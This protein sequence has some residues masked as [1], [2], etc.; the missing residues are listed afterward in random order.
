MRIERTTDRELIRSVVTHPA[1][2]P[3]VSDDGSPDAG[4]YEPVIGD[5]IL[6]LAAWAGD[7]LAG[8]FM[9]HPAN[10]ATVEIHTCILPAHRG[11]GS[12][13]AAMAVL[14]W[15][16]ANTSFHK[17][18]THVPAYNRL[19]RRLALSVGMQDEGVNRKSFLKGGVL[20][21]QYL[22]GITRQECMKCQ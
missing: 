3:H 5:S 1:I 4:Q 19:A 13:A 10:T 15:L 6:W 17:V 7:D 9:A 8:L 20:Q 18:I 22:L 21:D 2:Y 12:K 14:E 16:F 11:T